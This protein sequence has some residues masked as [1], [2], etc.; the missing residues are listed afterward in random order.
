M[1]PPDNVSPA[2]YMKAVE[3]AAEITSQRIWATVLTIIAVVFMSSLA[4]SCTRPA[5]IDPQEQAKLQNEKEVKIACIS[6][7]GS[8]MPIISKRYKDNDGD[9]QI[10]TEMGCVQPAAL[11]VVQALASGK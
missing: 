1:K 9:I 7:G 6:K 2:E 11:A 4:Y 3:Q 5:T 8:W 10:Q